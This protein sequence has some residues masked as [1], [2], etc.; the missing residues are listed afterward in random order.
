MNTATQRDNFE[1]QFSFYCTPA[2]K[3]T[4]QSFTF[5][6]IAPMPCIGLWPKFKDKI[7]SQLLSIENYFILSDTSSLRTH[8]FESNTETTQPEQNSVSFTAE[9]I[10]DED[11][12]DS[13]VD[14]DVSFSMSPLSKY[15]VQLKIKEVKN[16]SPNIFDSSEI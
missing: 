1:D 11:I 12:Y 8:Y 16:A 14:N 15:K 13:M 10:T 9:P 4:I 5:E 6:K 2:P 7:Q 3:S